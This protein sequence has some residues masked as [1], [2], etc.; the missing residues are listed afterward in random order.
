MFRFKSKFKSE[1]GHLIFGNSFKSKLL[2]DGFGSTIAKVANF[3][4]IFFSSVVL[5]RSMGAENYGVYGY[6]VSIITILN[7]PAEFGLP[8]LVI[9]ETAKNVALERW[10]QLRG[11]WKW[12]TRIIVLFT[13]VLLFGALVFIYIWGDNF[14]D[15][16]SRTLFWAIL[17][18]PFI[19]LGHLRKSQ[20]YGLKKVVLGQ[21]P[22]QVL[23]PTLTIIIVLF[24]STTTPGELTAPQAMMIRLAA[25]VIAFVVGTVLVIRNYPLEIKKT[26]PLKEVRAW[27]RSAIPFAGNSGITLLNNQAGILILGLFVSPAEIGYY[28]I[29]ASLAITVAIGNQIIANVA[30]PQFAS[31]FVE[32]QIKRLQKLVN[33]GAKVSFIISFCALLFFLF[34][35][36]PFLSFIYGADFIASYQPLLILIVGQLVNSSTG[37]VA[38]LLNMTGKEKFTLRGTAIS[39]FTNIILNFLLTP[40]MGLF[41]AAI[42]TAVS[43]IIFNLFLFLVARKRLN[44]TSFIINF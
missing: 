1:F 17:L 19:S 7:I 6:V 30:N 32:N 35:G 8:S 16:Y 29:A 38:D 31:L 26:E 28:K 39:S 41:G 37:P 33:I 5:V 24:I 9:R 25:S 4:L 21:L 22:E 36:K 43:L 11:L 44:I 10:G 42:A 12:A 14:G 18:L 3:L 40:R 27:I 2:K 23:L 20:L 13:V 15:A 34:F